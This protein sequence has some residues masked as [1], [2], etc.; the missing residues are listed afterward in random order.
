MKEIKV[1]WTCDRVIYFIP[2]CSAY[3]LTHTNRVKIV[4]RDCDESMTV[5]VEG[6]QKTVIISQLPDG[7]R[8]RKKGGNKCSW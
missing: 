6:N 5:L 3:C 2:Y 8:H 1:F 4:A 7:E